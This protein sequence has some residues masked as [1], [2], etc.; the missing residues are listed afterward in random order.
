[1]A[2]NNYIIAPSPKSIIILCNDVPLKYN[3][4]IKSWTLL[5]SKKMQK[6][7]LS[8]AYSRKLMNK[9]KRFQETA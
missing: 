1:M 3:C 6:K 8:L 5:W 7:S 9:P 4:I 2:V